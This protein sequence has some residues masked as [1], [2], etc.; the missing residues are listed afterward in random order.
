MDEYTPYIETLFLDSDCV[1]C[2]DFS[3]Q[4]GNIR[5]KEFSPVC[6]TYLTE[7]DS[8][9]YIENLKETLQTLNSDIFPKFN[10][11]LYYFRK[12]PLSSKV[13]H[14]AK[15]ILAKSSLYGVKNFDL[16][17]PNEETIFSLALA[18][19]GFNDLYNDHG[20]F[21]Q[22]T[23]NIKNLKIYPIN[24]HCSFTKH[25]VFVE[26]AICHFIRSNTSNIHYLKCELLLKRHV[27]ILKGFIP[28]VVAL[29]KLLK[30][31]SLF[32][33]KRLYFN[34]FIK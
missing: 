10:G 32:L 5:K 7:N 11:G 28:N 12:G 22:T 15:E 27:G 4:L 14:T 6:A 1:V 20:K 30:N 19:L 18:Q 16:A 26:P 25:N 17:G 21:M 9:P 2:K 13:F 23:N 31:S 8:D 24:G 33:I 3:G 34:I 29:V